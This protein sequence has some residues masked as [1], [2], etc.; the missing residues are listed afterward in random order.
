MAGE[1]EW[2]LVEDSSPENRELGEVVRWLEGIY[3]GDSPLDWTESR[4]RCAE[5][6]TV[7]LTSSDKNRSLARRLE[8]A[9]YEIGGDEHLVVRVD[10][11]PDRVFKL[12]HGDCFG[13]YSF[14]SPLDPDLTGKHF[15]GSINEDP[16]FYL[17][18][19]MLLNFLG[20]YQTRFEG[21]LP[22]E[23]KLRMPRICV[24]QPTLDVP[25]P[26]RKEILESLA[27][28]RFVH[29]SDDAFL[30]FETR[31]LLTDAAPRNVRI[32]DGT[33]ALFDAI[34]SLASEE[35]Y[36]WASRRTQKDC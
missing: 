30:N 11:Q 31:I 4:R 24:S 1:V 23:E 14:F 13:C 19:W 16:V 26:T 10:D 6:L 20:G 25:S 15:H 2:R 3:S 34:A 35:I 32:V 29:I 7:L 12:T 22:P 17:K 8:G 9:E 18:R 36:E 5:A 21:L 27:P 28:Y 33:P